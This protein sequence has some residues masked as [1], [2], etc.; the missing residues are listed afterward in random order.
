MAR[1]RG[2][3]VRPLTPDRWDD[4]VEL[5]GERGAYG[6]CWCMY[7]RLGSEF[8]EGARDH[9][10]KNRAAM[11]RIVRARR[12]PG[13]L[14]YLDG[15]PVGWVSVA[16]RQEF[17]KIE[18][19]RS[20]RPVDDRPAWSIVCFY[21]DRRHRG[22]GVASALLRAAVDHARANGARLVEAYPVDPKRRA[23]IP[24][25]EAYYG[26][27]PMF[28]AAGFREVERRIPWRPI[29]RRALRPPRRS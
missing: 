23:K 6:G 12:V 10:R 19:A 7:F 29:M 22:R 18:R 17:G 20:T 16:P 27:V 13:L 1:T 21:I 9:G 26:V 3:E 25:S 24:N 2:I 14:G 4:L 15:R 28:E 5:F 11:Q 8:Q